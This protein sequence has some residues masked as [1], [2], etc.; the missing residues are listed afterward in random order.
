[1]SK[2]NANLNLHFTNDIPKYWA[3]NNPIITHF[4]NAVSTV[5]PE[6]EKLFIRSLK[7]FE[8]N[9]TDTQL[10]QQVRLFILQEAEHSKQHLAMN[11]W[12]ANNGVIS[13][14]IAARVKTQVANIIKSTSEESLLESTIAMEH[15]STILSK[16][17]LDNPTLSEGF[18]PTMVQLF[19]WH[20]QEELEHKTVAFDVYCSLNNINRN[21]WQR[22][23]KLM[24]IALVIL[25]KVISIQLSYIIAE[26][27][28]FNFSAW[29]RAQWYF[30]GNPGWFRKILPDFFK[31]F[32][33]DF[34]P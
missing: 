27:Q 9:I 18:H 22:I 33:F 20:S 12:L 6:G 21:Y 32:R 23:S 13:D 7:Q 25:P 24:F 19:N 5:I 8:R 17:F 30:W 4:F 10:Q 29:T 34:T 2:A 16:H 15:L 1:M 14:K 11:Q 26:R 3:N 28:F 31:F